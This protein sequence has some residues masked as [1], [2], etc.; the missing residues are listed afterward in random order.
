MPT[1]LSIIQYAYQCH[2]L[3]FT[4]MVLIA[5]LYF[6]AYCTLTYDTVKLSTDY[7]D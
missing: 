3:A 5:Y 7:M 2:C 1:I 6:I 4:M